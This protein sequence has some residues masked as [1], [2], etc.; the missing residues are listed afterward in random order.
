MNP[1]VPSTLPWPDTRPDDAAPAAGWLRPSA[2]LALA[3][4]LL[5]PFTISV[6]G[7]FPVGELVLL[8]VVGW[9][10]L[11]VITH[12]TAPGPLFT[13]RYLYVLL[14][15]ELVALLAYMFSDFYRHS[16]PKDMARGWARMILLGLDVV[17][18]AYLLGRSA[19]N[20]LWFLAGQ[21]LGDLANAVFFGA[22]FGD[23]W[24]FGYGIPVTYVALMLAGLAGRVA[25]LLAAAGLGALHFALD[26]RSVGGLCLL[27]AAAAGLQLL[28]RR[29]R[30]W[31]LPC[32]VLATAALAAAIFS[33]VR[34]GDDMEHR[35]SR[36]DVD[37]SSMLQAAGEAFRDSP[38]VGHG[39]WFSRTDVYENFVQIRADRAKEAGIGGFAGPN[40]EP[41]AVALHSQ[42]LVT[43]AEGGI[44][45]ASFFFVYGAGLLWALW[46]QIMV[47]AWRRDL[48]VRVFQ[49][50]LASWHLVMSP[51]SGA[52]RVYIALAA[53]I[54]L[55]VQAERRAEEPA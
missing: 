7:E 41:E 48:P 35:A 19:R 6:V 52:H 42:I 47:A 18:I 17:A 46:N 26:F 12:R 33:H 29:A 34:S 38:L 40:E 51:F 39:S 43:L 32:C 23:A 50:C 10:G 15:C 9:V 45:G 3:A 5:T 14:V 8:V 44:F 49:L 30:L 22:L 4:G 11:C 20:F 54:I 28:P 31:A 27:V 24:K 21:M 2:L 1:D 25:V 55:L 13:Q 36:S 53:G 37:R 16:F